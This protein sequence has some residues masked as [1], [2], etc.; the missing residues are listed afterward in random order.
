MKPLT[1]FTCLFL[2]LLW[3]TAGGHAEEQDR[4]SLQDCIA[5]ATAKAPKIEAAEAVRQMRTAELSSAQK[6]LLP[7][8]SAGYLYQW[9]PDNRIIFN[10]TG[11]SNNYFAYNFT[12]EQPLYK[13][14]SLITS[15]KVGE[16][17]VQTSEFSYDSRINDLVLEV[18][19]AYYDYLKN[20]KL[21][22][23]AGQAIE[24]LQSHLR[25]ARAFYEA[26]LIPKNDLLE[27][28]VQL[29]QGQLDLLLAQ[30]TTE[31][32]RTSLN[33]LL[34]RP[35][36]EELHVQDIAEVQ[37]APMEWQSILDRAL[38]SRP[39]IASARTLIE[40][41]DKETTLARAPY[42]PSL[43]VSASYLKQGEDFFAR[44]Y[45]GL[46]SEVKQAVA[47]AS[48]RFWSWGQNDAREAASMA[49]KIQAEKELADLIDT[50]TKQTRDAFLNHERAM[51]N[52]DVTRT[53]V[54]FAEEN[55]RIN[56]ARYQAQ[57]NTST[58]VLDALTLL[59]Q[60]KANF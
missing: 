55:Y 38:S 23:V 20:G 4:L 15:V 24:R 45:D 22:E 13:G 37:P 26:G 57:L 18:S 5:I 6:D 21:Q 44:N 39:E 3:I 53:A 32:S 28:E 54:E 19:N 50:I 25:D 58:Q 33:L 59:S 49:K 34:R 36:T 12:V 47:R 40:I 52:I 51:K 48:W 42:L 46:E 27:S 2:C 43:A 8:L 56:E 7:V 60:A 10:N 1:F 17:Q 31:L 30:N 9:Q 14:K 41:S 16:L 35:V 11:T 29:S